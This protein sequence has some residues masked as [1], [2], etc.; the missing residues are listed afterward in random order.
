METGSFNQSVYRFCTHLQ[1]T[2]QRICET[3]S[4]RAWADGTCS[5]Q[6]RRLSQRTTGPILSRRASWPIHTVPVFWTSA[7]PC[8]YEQHQGRPTS[9]SCS[10]GVSKTHY[11]LRTQLQE[12]DGSD[13]S[14]GGTERPQTL[15]HSL[16]ADCD[17]VGIKA[18]VDGAR[19]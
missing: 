12:E 10:W 15:P 13:S 19:P 17:S 18:Q 9:Q 14:T 3:R 6:S 1:T 4:S 11:S 16:V 5:Q 2:P 7:K 8:C